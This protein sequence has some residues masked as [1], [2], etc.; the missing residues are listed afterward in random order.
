[1]TH[2]FPVKSRQSLSRHRTPNRRRGAADSEA[3][4]TPLA[5][6]SDEPFAA[7]FNELRERGDKEKFKQ[8]GNLFVLQF[9]LKVAH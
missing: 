6:M 1:L 5:E 7:L 8:L 3:G 9:A 4:A 2:I